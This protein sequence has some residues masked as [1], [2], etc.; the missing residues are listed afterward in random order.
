MLAIYDIKNKEKI[1]GRYGIVK[2][3][4]NDKIVNFQEKPKR[5]KTSL[6]NTGC[7]ILPRKDL[8]MIGEYLKEGN[9]PDA[10]GYF[11]RWLIKKKDVYGYVFDDPWFDIGSFEAY[12]EAN[13]FYR[14]QRIKLITDRKT[15]VNLKGK[16]D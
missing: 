2:I 4:K 7:F 8:N 15:V 13:K 10:L 3:D 12:N 1:K 9:S 14:E 11:I 16:Q 6:V 5:P